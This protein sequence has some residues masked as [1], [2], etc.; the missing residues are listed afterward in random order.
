MPWTKQEH[1]TLYCLTCLVNGK[2]YIGITSRA[3]N[4][5]WAEHRRSRQSMI[6]AAIRKYGI[7]NFVL[8]VLQTVAH[9]QEAAAAERDWIA[10]H[11]T[12]APQGYN[13]NAGGVFNE[14]KLSGDRRAETSRANAAL[15]TAAARLVTRG[16]KRDAELVAK[17]AAS[18]RGRKRSAETRAN[19]SMAARHR[20]LKQCRNGHPYTENNLIINKHG[21][22]NCRICLKAKRQRQVTRH[23][24]AKEFPTS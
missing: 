18:H 16:R 15:A 14:I 13:L 3:P 17:T 1:W 22:Q 12:M 6:G 2:A 9:A 7:E 21:H 5:R 19:I 8:D 4:E 23:S 10:F 24:V 20:R 11:D